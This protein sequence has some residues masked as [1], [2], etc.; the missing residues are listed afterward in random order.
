MKNK[1]FSLILLVSIIVI[2]FFLLLRNINV[3]GTEP[4]SSIKIDIPDYTVERVGGFDYVEIPGG[5]TLLEDGKPRVPYYIKKINYDQ[6]YRVQ[7]VTLKVKDGLI[8]AK[9]LKLPIVSMLPDSSSFNM[10]EQ[11]LANE[12]FPGNDYDWQIT[13]NPDNTT[14][15]I[16]NIYPFFYNASTTEAKFYKK[17]EFEIKFITSTVS[18]T[19]LYK[20]KDLY[21]LGETVKLNVLL[22]NSDDAK[23]VYIN[24]LVRVGAAPD[25]IDSLQLMSI[26][27]LKGDGL[28]T[29]KWDTN[30]FKTSNYILETSIIDTS[31]NILDKEEIAVKIGKTLIEVKSFSVSPKK[32]QLGEDLDITLSFK[33]AGSGNVSGTCIFKVISDN[34]VKK[35]LRHAF[36]D[37][38]RD[39]SLT[40]SDKWST[41][42]AEKGKTYSVIGYIIYESQ[43]TE[44]KRELVSTN[45]PPSANF[46]ISPEKVFAQK[47]I[48][49]DA[50]SSF[51][52]DGSIESF[53]W[54]FGDGAIAESEVVIHRFLQEGDY[55]VTLTVVN[56]VG[57][58]STITKKVIVSKALNIPNKPL[59]LFASE[60]SS[61]EIKLSWT[62]NSDNEDGFK[63]ERKV[64]GGSFTEIKTLAANSTIYTDTGLTP[65]TTYYYRVRAY[66][67]AGDSDYSNEASAMTMKAVEKIIIRLYI[68]KKAYYVNDIEKE[69]DVAPIIYEERTLLPIRYVAEALGAEVSWNDSEKKVIITFKD[70]TIELW[71]GKNSAK[72][73][74]AYKFIDPE[75]PK[76]T[77]IIIPPGRTMLPIRFIAENMGC[78]VDWDANLREVKVTYP[79]E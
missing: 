68:D 59:N 15:L 44:I 71:I 46:T 57:L 67:T 3:R 33:N 75:N 11:E 74:G 49:F 29:Q 70:I 47:D 64:L 31:N 53:K 17:Y 38:K 73:N 37:L 55:D 36:N 27:G 12:W 56:N 32:F 26:K 45:S 42:E 65:N 30:G 77:P 54:D 18:I 2:S 60:S 23:D 66:N 22:N 40:I 4:P 28:V 52:P 41:V 63:L 35:E 6:I 1:R 25:I 19:G 72:V 5:D 8:T 62:D 50:S 61:T 39:A 43:S 79:A 34:D 21:D 24:T 51:D 20:E 9:D 13:E 78:K 69:M 16:L 76:V 14:T 7:D 58:T 48:T 10:T